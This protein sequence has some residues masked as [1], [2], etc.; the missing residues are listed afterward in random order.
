MSGSNWE[1]LSCPACGTS[2]LEG[3]LGYGCSKPAVELRGWEGA[4][5]ER[6]F[7]QLAGMDHTA[8]LAL[9]WGVTGEASRRRSGGTA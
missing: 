5:V 7:R 4:L 1:G 6:V 3:C 9:L 8:L 2:L